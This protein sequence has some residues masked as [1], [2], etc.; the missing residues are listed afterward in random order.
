MLD[1]AAAAALLGALP[2]LS[3]DDRQALI[4]QGQTLYLQNGYTTAVE[5][6]A[7]LERRTAASISSAEMAITRS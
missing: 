1:G 2:R 4:Q 3:A 5:G 7:R 6:R